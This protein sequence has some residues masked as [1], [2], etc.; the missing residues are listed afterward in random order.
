MGA[1]GIKIIQ[2]RAS[3][4]WGGV[5]AAA[6]SVMI[7]LSLCPLFPA[8]FSQLG[9]RETAL[10]LAISCLAVTCSWVLLPDSGSSWSFPPVF[11]WHRETI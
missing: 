8:G 4:Q 2:K 9:W 6:G 3:Q 5:F 10:Q 11:K 7:G 1:L